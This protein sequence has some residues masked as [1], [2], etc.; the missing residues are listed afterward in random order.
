MW[1]GSRHEQL[2][3][4]AGCKPRPISWLLLGSWHSLLLAFPLLQALKVGRSTRGVEELDTATSHALDSGYGVAYT[5]CRLQPM[6][7]AL[8]GGLTNKE[9]PGIMPRGEEMK[10]PLQRGIHAVGTWPAHIQNN[11]PDL[12]PTALR[13]RPKVGQRAHESM[14]IS[15]DLHQGLETLR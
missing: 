11:G 6:L 12:A 8:L 1:S 10:R 14:R 5:W 13:S 2:S 9:C 4:W 7:L 3:T 15:K